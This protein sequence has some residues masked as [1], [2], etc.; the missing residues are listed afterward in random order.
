MSKHIDLMYSDGDAIQVMA[1]VD[2][3]VYAKDEVPCIHV[4]DVVYDTVLQKL[5]D[6]EAFLYPGK[7]TVR[8][9]ATV[10]H[11]GEAKDAVSESGD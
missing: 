1:D 9:M 7:Y 8:L 10:V 4:A 3:A 11:E 2:F 6:A 5:K